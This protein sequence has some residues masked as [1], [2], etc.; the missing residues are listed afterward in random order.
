MKI[1][2]I[3]FERILKY[4]QIIFLLL[5]II[6]ATLIFFPTHNFQAPVAQGDHGRDLYAFWQTSQGATPYQ[7][8]LWTYGPLMPYY[9]GLV[10]KILGSTIQSALL[11]ELLLKIISITIF[12]LL[13]GCLVPCLWAFLGAMWL[14]SFF[15]HVSHTYNH[16]GAIAAILW[17]ALNLF[18]YLT[19]QRKKFLWLG[20]LSIAIT[21]L[22]KIN[23]G[24]YGLAAFLLSVIVIDS[25]QKRIKKN[26][27]IYLCGCLATSAAVSALHLLFIQKLPMYYILQ[28]FPVLKEYRQRTSSGFLGATLLSMIQETCMGI[29]SSPFFLTT[30]ILVAT[31]VIL[32]IFLFKKNKNNHNEAKLFWEAMFSAGIFFFVCLHEYLMSPMIYSKNWVKPFGI[33]L[34]FLVIGATAKRLPKI[35]QAVLALFLGIVIVHNINIMHRFVRLFKNPIHHFEMNKNNVYITNGPDWFLTVH[36]TVLFLRSTLKEDELFF[37]LPC[38]PLYYF[39]AER[40][41]PVREFIFFDFM[42]IPYEQEKNIIFK[43]ET[44]KIQYIVLSNR[45]SSDE[46][47]TGILGKTYCPLLARYITAYFETIE[48]FGDWNK[49]AGWVTNHATK[50]LRRKGFLMPQPSLP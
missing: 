22:I 16:I 50:I 36:K 31:G 27:K 17:T 14:A 13:L 7:D 8:Y 33:L 44:Q 43:L 38:D 26:F 11:G 39:L 49:P 23:I 20:F 48:T 34:I 6:A 40:R 42:N 24:I 45:Y 12:Y 2:K 3:L 29:F 9:Y 15:P 47:G 1:L 18:L 28:C 4:R 5:T 10:F 37:A 35:L 32:L 46:P 41:S 25:F 30:F 21:F 19:T